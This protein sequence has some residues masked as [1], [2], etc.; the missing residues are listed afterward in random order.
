MV[1]LTSI[2]SYIP[3]LKFYIVGKLKIPN[4]SGK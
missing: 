3:N 4:S 2:N 1:K